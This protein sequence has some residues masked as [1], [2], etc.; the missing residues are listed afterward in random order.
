[1]TTADSE[2]RSRRHDPRTFEVLGRVMEILCFAPG[3]LGDCLAFNLWPMLHGGGY[4]LS[5]R[6]VVPTED[7]VAAHLAVAAADDEMTTIL[8]PGD[9]R[10][11][12]GHHGRIVEVRGVQFELRPEA[13]IRPEMYTAMGEYWRTGELTGV[14]P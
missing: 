9:V 12:S 1:M 5:W 2:V 11:G 10:I 14:N 7:E 13:M 3:P 8:R 4:V 6:G